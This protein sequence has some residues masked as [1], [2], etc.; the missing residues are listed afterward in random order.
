MDRSGWTQ[1]ARGSLSPWLSEWLWL[2]ALLA[3]VLLA[4]GAGLW[5]QARQQ[6]RQAGVLRVGVAQLGEGALFRRGRAGEA[7]RDQI[8]TR[9]QEELGQVEPGRTPP[10]LELRPIGLVRS[11]REAR[12]RMEREGLDLLLWGWAP[13]GS[14]GE[15]VL[16]LT[17]RKGDPHLEGRWAAVDR[18]PPYETYP[19]TVE[20]AL[21]LPPLLPLLRGYAWWN[22]G[23]FLWAQEALERGV[24]AYPEVPALQALQARVLL[25]LDRY[26]EAIQALQRGID[27]QG[28]DSAAPGFWTLLG[29]AWAR[30]GKAAEAVN[31]WAR[32][33]TE[34]GLEGETA[35]EDLVLLLTDMD[36]PRILEQTA[37]WIQLC[38]EQVESGRC[39]LAAARY[40]RKG[41]DLEGA[42]EALRAAE[43]RLGGEDLLV[44]L[45][46]G[47][48]EGTKGRWSAAIRE[49]EQ[50]RSLLD[51]RLA[52]LRDLEARARLKGDGDLAAWAA[53]QQGRILQERGA[54]VAYALGWAYLAQARIQGPP[55][56]LD[57]FLNRNTPARKAVQ[58]FQEATTWDPTWFEAVW[59]LAQAWLQAEM[60]RE[61]EKVCDRLLKL[62]PNR[63]EGY[64]C[65]AQVARRRENREQEVENL[66]RALEK[67]PTYLPA[68]RR[69][70]DLLWETG[71]AKW[72]QEELRAE[73]EADLARAVDLYDRAYLLDPTDLEVLL[74][75]IRGRRRLGR[76]EEAE[77]ILTE[78]LKRHGD[79]PRLLYELGDLYR[80]RGELDRA[81]G[82]LIRA[83]EALP[84]DPEVNYALGE[85]ARRK[86]QLQKA[87]RYWRTAVEARP[88]EIRYIQALGELLLEEGRY[89]E[90]ISLFRDASRR[91]QDNGEVQYLWGL[92]YLRQGN[93]GQAT[94]LLGRALEQ[95]LQR[96]WPP[97]RI[98]DLRLAYGEAWVQAGR[99]ERALEQAEE[100]LALDPDSA[101]GHWI[102]AEARL[103]QVQDRRRRGLE[104]EAR[105]LLDQALADLERALELDP[106]FFPAALTRARILLEEGLPQEAL[107]QV[108]AALS[109]RPN[110]PELQL[111][112]G[113]ALLELGPDRRP[114]AEVAF[115]Q[116]ISQ[117]H[118]PEAYY[119]WGEILWERGEVEPARRA[120]RQAWERSGRQHPRAA[121]A[122]GWASETLGRQ[123]E[124]PQEAAQR[125]EEAAR[126]YDRAAQTDPDW[127]VP[128]LRRA[129]VEM[130]LD[131][132]QTA[133]DALQEALQREP[134]LAEAHALLGDAYRHQGRYL[135]AISA[136]RNALQSLD[137]RADLWFYLAESYRATGQLEAALEAYQKALDP[138]RIGLS[139]QMRVEAERGIEEVRAALGQ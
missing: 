73:G 136:Y 121:Y 62:D 44:R 27:L 31:A 45:E 133:I 116:A 89:D 112:R 50:A 21:P 24:Q 130:L 8:L 25:L 90:A 80:E 137:G 122:L 120:F 111:L 86:G 23:R 1:T 15:A 48:L 37:P 16:F 42:T 34:P 28:E 43:R 46:R 92:A 124:D 114:E 78:A 129:V 56:I 33:G 126:W 60:S 131:R 91:V 67:D 41:G 96:G 51:L 5:W 71:L 132:W 139:P 4:G 74:R 106:A 103:L 26:P 20:P 59:G 127:G 101:R 64:D 9:L 69:R 138:N 94:K 58:A 35:L 40:R 7:L 12:E 118:L 100:A 11:E 36:D 2:W 49:L 77:A 68:L 107:A 98:L 38:V 108:N 85:I 54:P 14:L 29:L 113:L 135:D 83:W 105:T 55:G 6:A 93:A 52:A 70:A 65:W 104:E 3:L 81:E 22:E 128:L 75:R 87:E 39:W 10:P 88:E 102:R 30:S 17:L 18:L 84:R 32:V 109:H 61:A 117:A 66:E 19:L 119:R 13:P 97:E 47:L 115:R 125:L 76:L 63:P 82:L 79:H 53:A 110:H 57:R 72:G 123:S 99:A 134:T 95:A